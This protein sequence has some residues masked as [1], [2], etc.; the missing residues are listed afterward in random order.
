MIMAN[1]ELPVGD[2]FPTLTKEIERFGEVRD[3]TQVP[4]PSDFL[5]E[6]ISVVHDS[7]RFCGVIFN[8]ANPDAGNRLLAFL[9]ANKEMAVTPKKT[10]TA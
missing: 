4:A 1:N 2:P 8:Y 7:I 3:G 9:K 10:L 6:F 5:S